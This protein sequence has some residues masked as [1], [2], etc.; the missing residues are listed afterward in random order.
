LHAVSTARF[1]N[2]RAPAVSAGL[3]TPDHR[4]NEHEFQHR[5]IVA[6]GMPTAL[7]AACPCRDAGM[8]KSCRV[9]TA[10]LCQNGNA[11]PGVVNHSVTDE[12][13]AFE[14]NARDVRLARTDR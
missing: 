4:I 1:R 8:I 11:L 5:A 6:I 9:L 12:R 13:A 3:R 10:N 7:V 2:S 14:D